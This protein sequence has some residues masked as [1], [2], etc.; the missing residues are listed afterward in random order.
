MPSYIGEE[1]IK[2]TIEESDFMLGKTYVNVNQLLVGIGE[3]II[4]VII[5]TTWIFEYEHAP[6]MILISLFHIPI[7]AAFV[8]SLFVIPINF[9][10]WYSNGNGWRY[11]GRRIML[12]YLTTQ[13][14]VIT[15][16]F[17]DLIWRLIIYQTPCVELFPVNNCTDRDFVKI[18]WVFF[19]M[20]ISSFTLSSIGLIMGILVKSKL[21]NK[22]NYA[23]LSSSFNSLKISTTFD[24]EKPERKGNE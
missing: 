24:I 23:A 11:R 8:F 2:K 15:C 14:F 13:I 16:I 4:F 20:D 5:I 9:K 18:A 6:T 7:I 22:T 10:N 21:K 17:G 12:F 3:L 1:E 19:A